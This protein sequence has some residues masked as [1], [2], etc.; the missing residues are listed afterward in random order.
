MGPETE[1]D[2][3]TYNDEMIPNGLLLIGVLCTIYYTSN[4][5]VPLK[6]IVLHWS[7]VVAPCRM[8]GNL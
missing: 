8:L 3:D 6:D 4:G 2:R 7:S 5:E 1:R